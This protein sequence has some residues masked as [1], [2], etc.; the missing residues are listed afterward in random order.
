[1]KVNSNN[2]FVLSNLKEKQKFI[3]FLKS[4]TFNII[5]FL[6][7]GSYSL[8]Y[9]DII[10][11]NNTNSI[12]AI[13]NKEMLIAGGSILRKRILSTNNSLIPL[14]SEHF[15]LFRL[16]P[17]NN[18]IKKVYITASGGPFY[19]KKDINL[20]RVSFKNVLKHPKWKMGINNSIDSSNFVNKI[21]EIFELSTI[22]NIDINKIDFLVSKEAFIHSCVIFKDNTIS[23]NCF[24]NNMLI[25][26][27]KPI[28]VLFDLDNFNFNLKK[29][30]NLNNFRLQTFKD[31]R[32]KIPLKLNKIKKFNHSEQIN[33]MIFNNLAH[34][35]YMK[36]DISYNA[37]PNF[38][39]KK[40]K[41]C[42]I[43]VNLKSFHDILKYV[44][45][46]EKK[47]A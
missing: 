30:F 38:I 3:K 7:Y 11:K 33:F 47:Y 18:E 5:Y 26:L 35:C 15:S 29:N 43:K 36:G 32:F 23:I 16:L 46:L 4:K 6:D 39:F 34:I 41:S 19:F 2:N 31:S 14:D 9:L 45:L 22:Y 28:S 10:L 25:P 8:E 12:L 37:I 1:M 44:K 17:K 24:S 27:L 40:M 13:A 42:Q 20:D 21:L